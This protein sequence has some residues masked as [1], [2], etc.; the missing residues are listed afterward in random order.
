VL[1]NP[2]IAGA[3]KQLGLAV[4][5]VVMAVAPTPAYAAPPQMVR[6]ELNSMTGCGADNVCLID[7]VR[8]DFPISFHLKRGRYDSAW[9]SGR[10][11]Q[12]WDSPDGSHNVIV[13]SPPAVAQL[14]FSRDWT[15]AQQERGG[16]G[17]GL[18][19]KCKPLPAA[20]R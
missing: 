8:N 20:Q 12:A 1:L 14:A 7:L 5:V 4:G 3:F 19:Y 6:C 13:S 9:G 16:A 2:P 18:S 17:S 11:T 15:S 10:I